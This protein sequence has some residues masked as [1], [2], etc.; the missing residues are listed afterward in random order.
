MTTTEGGYQSNAIY[1]QGFF[2]APRNDNDP[3]PNYDPVPSGH[4]TRQWKMRFFFSLI[5]EVHSMYSI[6]KMDVSALFF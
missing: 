5:V 3:S 4:G 1:F 2:L 6:L